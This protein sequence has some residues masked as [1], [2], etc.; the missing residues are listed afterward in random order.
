MT[1]FQDS[2][3]PTGDVAGTREPAENLSPS[4]WPRSGH[5]PPVLSP[6]ELAAVREA[7]REVQAQIR[8]ALDEGRLNDACRL[9]DRARLLDRIVFGQPMG[10]AL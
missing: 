7:H 6:A 2:G 9:T 1:S 5:N 3:R 10:R 4:A 8:S